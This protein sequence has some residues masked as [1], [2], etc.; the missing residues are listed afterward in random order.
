MITMAGCPAHAESAESEQELRSSL[1]AQKN[2][3]SLKKTGRG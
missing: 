2:Q 1:F 3:A